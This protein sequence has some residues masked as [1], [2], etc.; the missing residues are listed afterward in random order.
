MVLVEGL[1][2]GE[3]AVAARNFGDAPVPRLHEVPPMAVE[4]VAH[5]A[6]PGGAGETAIVAA[7]G[8]VANAVAAAT[9]LRARQLPLRADALLRHLQAAG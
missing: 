6:P 7:A 5:A 2:V 9:G 8:A 4:L 3:G 1:A